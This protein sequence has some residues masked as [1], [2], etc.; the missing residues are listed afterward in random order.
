VAP[1]H[2]DTG[3][4]DDAADGHATEIGDPVPS[5]PNTTTHPY[6]YTSYAKPHPIPYTIS[7]ATDTDNITAG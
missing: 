7:Y 4:R 3:T 2:L 6:Q 5:N 1:N